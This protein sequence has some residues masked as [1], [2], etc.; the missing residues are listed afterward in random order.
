M[1]HG[2]S[3]QNSLP[4]TV[5]S[6]HP[7]GALAPLL[8]LYVAATASQ[9]PGGPPATCGDC[10]EGDFNEPRIYF[11]WRNTTAA[12]CC[13]LCSANTTCAFAI[14]DGTVGNCFPSPA[15]S[16]GFKSQGGIRACRT[17]TAPPWPK[18]SPPPPPPFSLSVWPQVS[19]HGNASGGSVHAG[20]SASVTVGCSGGGCPKPEALQWY[21][22]RLRTDAPGEPSNCSQHPTS[23]PAGGL[24][25]TVSVSVASDDYTVILPDSD[26]SYRI[27]CAAGAC[28]VSSASTVGAIRGLETLAHL[29]HD[30]AIPMPLTLTDAPRFPYR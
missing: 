14:H 7:V 16:T 8:L 12:E 28:A 29:A 10:R 3:P 30:Q 15:S 23:A 5:A 1:A 22:Q 6:M 19:L 26:E 9:R 2:G 21:Q 25:G 11:Y 13:D 17:S 4:A 24:V 27:S 18:P 20:T